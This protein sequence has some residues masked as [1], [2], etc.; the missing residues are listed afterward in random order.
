MQC[1]GDY[2]TTKIIE[3]G[4]GQVHFYWGYESLITESCLWIAVWLMMCLLGG[5]FQTISCPAHSCDILVD[6]NTVMWVS[7]LIFVYISLLWK[8]GNKNDPACFYLFLRL[9]SV[10]RFG[11]RHFVF[12]VSVH[13]HI[14][15]D[16]SGMP[17]GDFLIFGTTWTQFNWLDCG[18]QMWKLIWTHVGAVNEY[19]L[20][21]YI[22]E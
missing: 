9:C 13:T 11:R 22:L 20:F 1:W 8:V 6:D 16:C 14:R 21:K 12:L 2:L 19:S 15:S 17:E 7:V 5:F 4:M 18:G 10:A 3:E